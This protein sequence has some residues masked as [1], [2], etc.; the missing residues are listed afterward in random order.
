MRILHPPVHAGRQSRGNSATQSQVAPNSTFAQWRSLS[1]G[2]SASL[3]PRRAASPLGILVVRCRVQLAERIAE[4]A[5][6]GKGQ[7]ADA[8]RIARGEAATVVAN[9]QSAIGTVQTLATCHFLLTRM[10]Q[11]RK[12]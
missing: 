8:M 6:S 1:R 11:L 9:V 4:F 7:V 3:R 5:M 10:Q 2:R 12:Q